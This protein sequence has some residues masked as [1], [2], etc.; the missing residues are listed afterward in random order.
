MQVH[1][2]Y[3]KKTCSLSSNYITAAKL[4]TYLVQL[5][6]ITSCLSACLCVTTV[7]MQP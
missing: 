2:A 1:F 5:T 6:D 3:A 4:I 7:M